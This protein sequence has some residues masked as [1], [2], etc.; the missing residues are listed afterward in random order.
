MKKEEI[1]EKA[2]SKK[3][4]VG[5]ME[6]AKIQKSNWISVIVAGIIAVGFCI[7]EN[8]LRH[9]PAYFAIMAIIFAWA[10]TLYICQFAIAKRPWQVLIGAILYGLAFVA[11]IVLY[12][13]ANVQ[14]W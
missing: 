13:I 1:I 9:R 12:V 10:T 5:E 8:A 11:M 6:N 3:C 14:G 4:Y 7:S 2:K